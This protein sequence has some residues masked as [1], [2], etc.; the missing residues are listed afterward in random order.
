M[1]RPTPPPGIGLRC[2]FRRTSAV[3]FDDTFSHRLIG[4][5]QQTTTTTTTRRRRGDQPGE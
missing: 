1:L 4:G 2:P 5:Q 3:R